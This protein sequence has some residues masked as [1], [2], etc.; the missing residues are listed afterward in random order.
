LEDDTV[1]F[2]LA[3]T[4]VGFASARAAFLLWTNDGGVTFFFPFSS[5]G[6]TGSG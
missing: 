4:V 1:V 5:L 6:K 2:P 3:I